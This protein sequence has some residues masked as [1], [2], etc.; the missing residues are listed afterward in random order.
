MK[1]F[2][3][4]LIFLII[5]TIIYARFIGTS[6][7]K[8]N[9]YKIVNNDI[10]EEYHGLKIV[11]ITDI[12][13]GSTINEKRLDSLVNKINQLNPDIVVMTGDLMDERTKYDKETIIKS[14]SNINA[15]LGKY[16]I[17]GNHDIPIEDFSEII[18]SSGF[19]NLNNSYNL[20]YNNSNMPIV[21]SGISSN[22]NDQTELGIKTEKFDN[23]IASITEDNKPLFSILLIHEPD[24][25]DKLD[26]NRY[27]LV[28]AG[29]S[30]GGQVR[31]PI[32]EKIYIPNGAK[33]YFDK[34]YKIENTELFVSNG[35][36]TSG[37]K[38]RLFSRPS[39]NFYRLTNK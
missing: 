19:I 31:I 4:I 9:E 32:I 24:Y 30:H 38:F 1:K 26:I 35:I 23:Y 7:I 28:L 39:I 12:H 5:L 16:A 3:I 25:I 22:I 21:I 33:K 8:I 6:G 2:V 13:Y 29:H 27:N 18:E 14:L 17:S 37:P 10:T 15:K 34:Y 20:I 11:H 36:G